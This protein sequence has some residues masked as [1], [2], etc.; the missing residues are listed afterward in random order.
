M[1]KEKKPLAVSACLLG[2]NCKYNGGNNK[3]PEEVL[4]QL[5][6]RYR[7]I[8]I[9]PEELGGL[10]TPRSPAERREESVINAE[11]INVTRQFYDGAAAALHIVKTNH[12]SQA[13]LKSRSPS[14]GKGNIYDGSF[15]G[16][17][18]DRDGVTSECFQNEG[19]TVYTEEEL[20]QLV[21]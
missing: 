1:K 9:C 21:N 18:I 12:I 8:P 19:I 6:K 5:D 2:Q 14:C 11:G 7:L 13:L 10:P 15:T 4:A 17:L 16:T 20:N 3:L